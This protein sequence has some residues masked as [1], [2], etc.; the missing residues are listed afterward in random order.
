MVV[1]ICWFF[2]FDFKIFVFEKIHIP[3]GKNNDK[4]RLPIVIMNWFILCKA[5]IC[6][7]WRLSQVQ[8]CKTNHPCINMYRIC[9]PVATTFCTLSLNGNK[10]LFIYVSEQ[11]GPVSCVTLGLECQWFLLLGLHQDVLPCVGGKSW[12]LGPQSFIRYSKYFWDFNCL[13]GSWILF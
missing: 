3:Q 10:M 11:F 12:H 7:F 6:P 5:S 13:A 9:K 8:T 1:F 2:I 4:E